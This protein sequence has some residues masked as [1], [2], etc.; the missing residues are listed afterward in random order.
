MSFQNPRE[1]EVRQ[2]RGV[3]ERE[4]DR[5]DRELL[6][7]PLR[8]PRVVAVERAKAVGGGRAIFAGPMRVRAVVLFGSPIV[9]RRSRRDMRGA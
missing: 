4:H 3:A 2:R 7:E 9:L 1:D 8:R 5:P 6:V